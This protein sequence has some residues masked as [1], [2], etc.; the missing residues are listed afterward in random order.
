MFVNEPAAEK[1]FTFITGT[2][3]CFKLVVYLPCN[4]CRFV[5]VM[6]HYPL[7]YS[8]GIFHENRRINTSVSTDTGLKLVSV[9]T[10]LYYIRILLI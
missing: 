10:Y 4:N 3:V 1:L 5:S 2:L 8:L 7:R 6:T 9:K